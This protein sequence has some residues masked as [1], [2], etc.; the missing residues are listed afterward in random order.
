VE[1]AQIDERVNQRIDVCDGTS[2]ADVRALDAEGESLAVD[3]LHGSALAV[4]IFVFVAIPVEGV[5][6]PGTDAGGHH[7]RAAIFLPV[8]VVCRTPL[9]GTLGEAAR[10]DILAALMRDDGDGA[11][12]VRE[13]KR[14]D[15]PC[16][17]EWRTRGR[18][19]ATVSF[20]AAFF[21]EGD[22]GKGLGVVLAVEV[23]VDV[24]SVKSG[25]KS[26]KTG[27]KAECF[28]IIK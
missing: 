3:A 8:F 5:T 21:R 12:G 7:Y 20:V 15:Q 11:I 28:V 1:Q 22:G 4:D 17:T 6:Q 26:T 14:H 16:G 10:T 18:E 25:I 2:V 27:S 24:P 9:G 19:P 23:I 13:L